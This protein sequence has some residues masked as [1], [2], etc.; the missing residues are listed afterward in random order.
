M[1]LFAF[2]SFD[3]SARFCG[4][5]FSPLAHCAS[6]PLESYVHIGQEPDRDSPLYPP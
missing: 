1:G 5:G 2:H 3:A 4:K 6:L